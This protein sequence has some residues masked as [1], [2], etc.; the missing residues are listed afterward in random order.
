MMNNFVG[1]QLCLT[2][3]NSA[4]G[5]VSVVLYSQTSLFYF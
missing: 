1:I 3:L 2:S 5:A 4:A